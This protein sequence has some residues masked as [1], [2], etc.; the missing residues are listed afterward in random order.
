MSAWVFT[1]GTTCVNTVRALF[2]RTRDGTKRPSGR[3]CGLLYGFC[4]A[5]CSENGKLEQKLYRGT[6]VN[7]A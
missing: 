3:V 2:R 7:I 4:F 1:I 5:V 6:V